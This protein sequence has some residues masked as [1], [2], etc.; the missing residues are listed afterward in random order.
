[1]T[2]LE[3][4]DSTRSAAD[5]SELI[6]LLSTA[7]NWL[8]V[9]DRAFDR[10]IEVQAALTANAEQR[11]AGPVDLLIAATAELHNV[12]QL[13]DDHDFEQIAEATDQPM[14]WLAPAGIAGLS[15]RLG[16]HRAHTSRRKSRSALTS[17]TSIWA[18]WSL[19]A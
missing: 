18:F 2:E 3:I 8:P 5:R 7:Y 1:M 4:L 16:R 19:P 14:R 12:T 15:A 10:A 11:S 9:P 13:H 6:E 17:A